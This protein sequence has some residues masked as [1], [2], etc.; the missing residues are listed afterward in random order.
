MQPITL[1]C[2]LNSPTGEPTKAVFV[3]TNAIL[4]LLEREKPDMLV[5]AMDSGTQLSS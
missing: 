5:V 2:P 1:R 3:F 4:G